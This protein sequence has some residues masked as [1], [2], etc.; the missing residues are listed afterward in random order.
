MLL[1]GMVLK[2]YELTK[3]NGEGREK[4][5]KSLDPQFIQKLGESSLTAF[6]II[7]IT[8]RVLAVP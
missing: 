4:E 5:G 3:R 6:C 7:S 2:S 8:T 1:G